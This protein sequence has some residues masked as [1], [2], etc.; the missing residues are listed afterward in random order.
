MSA[1]HFNLRRSVSVLVAL[2]VLPFAQMASADLA[3]QDCNKFATTFDNFLNCNFKMAFSNE[4]Y[5]IHTSKGL[6][7]LYFAQAMYRAQSKVNSQA[8]KNLAESIQVEA[9]INAL[10]TDIGAIQS[11]AEYLNQQKDFIANHQANPKATMEAYR[12]FYAAEVSKNMTLIE[13]LER[14]EKAI[15]EVRGQLNEKTTAVNA[16]ISQV[17]A[18]AEV[19]TG[20]FNFGSI[21]SQFDNTTS[22]ISRLIGDAKAKL[23]TSQAIL[24]EA[25]AVAD[26]NGIPESIR[27]RIA[28]AQQSVSRLPALSAELAENQVKAEKLSVSIKGTERLAYKLKNG[29]RRIGYIGTGVIAAD[30]A[31]A[32]Y[33]VHFLGKDPTVSPLVSLIANKT[34]DEFIEMFSSIPKDVQIATKP[35]KR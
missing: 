20:Q 23:A 19:K 33:I 27:N 10:Q 16:Q 4:D 22:E 34:P 3:N 1:R 5:F 7:S 12:A 30:S 32:I 21:N 17:L 11:Q 26:S 35:A 31:G 15:N 18:Q 25:Q 14:A 9:R 6:V 8:A 29:L 28:A 24:A 2:S 13:N